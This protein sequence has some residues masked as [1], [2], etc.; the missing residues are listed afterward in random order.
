MPEMPEWAH[1]WFWARFVRDPRDMRSLPDQIPFVNDA[2]SRSQY[3]ELRHEWVNAGSVRTSPGLVLAA[4]TG[5]V[6]DDDGIPF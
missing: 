1:V 6:E 3:D 5:E 4:M 2:I